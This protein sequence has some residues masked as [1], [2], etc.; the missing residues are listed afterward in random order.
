M[1]DQP[2]RP[3]GEPDP[4]S[5]GDPLGGNEPPAPADK[6][7]S[8][9]DA[10]ADKG[11]SLPDEPPADKSPALPEEPVSGPFTGGSAAPF[12]E[13]MQDE[14]PPEEPAA[15]A[16]GPG[17]WIPE[18]SPVFGG[19]VAEPPAAEQPPPLTEVPPPVEPAPEPGPVFGAPPA[20]E[21]P[22]PAAPAG[23]GGWVP[24]AETPDLGA[25]APSEPAFTP[26]P[27]SEPPA[28]PIPPSEPPA[29]PGTGEA[30]PPTGLSAGDPLAASPPAPSG[31]PAPQAAPGAPGTPTPPEAVPPRVEGSIPPPGYVPQPG[32][33]GSGPVPPGAFQAAPP[34]PVPIGNYQLA[35]WGSRAVALIIDNI[36]VGVASILLFVIISGL[37][38]G[39]G[40]L[41]GDNGGAVGFFLGIAVA[42]IPVLIVSLLYMP[43]WMSRNDGATIGK[44]VMKIKVIR[45]NGQSTDFGWSALRQVVVIQGLFGF[46]GGIFLLGIPLLIDY[47]WPLWDEE[48]RALHDMLVQSRVVKA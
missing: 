29:L 37:F 11:P 15:P 30:P 39:L 9:P 22:A 34:P 43:Y 38:G 21:P 8:L 36:I 32:G 47:L 4:L 20:E 24:P 27:P 7:P 48:N 33:Y 18:D 12:G 6:G 35:S 16:A 3:D 23:P 46:L 5:S 2:P 1:E 45:V 42:F 13:A 14:P 31:F 17:G 28:P 41:A 19:P 10:P 44:Q 25:Q 40:S 26:V